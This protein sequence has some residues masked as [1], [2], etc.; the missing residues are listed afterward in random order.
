MPAIQIYDSETVIENFDGGTSG[1]WGTIQDSG[2]ATATITH[3]SALA[4]E[5]LSPFSGD[6]VARWALSGGDT[7]YYIDL[8]A[9]VVDTSETW[10]ILFTLLIEEDFTLTASDILPIFQMITTNTTTMEMGIRNNAGQYELYAG[11][12]GA[13]RTLPITRDNKKWYQIELQMDP[14]SGGATGTM[15]FRVDGNAVGAQIGSLQSADATKMWLGICNEGETLNSTSGHFMISDFILN[16][17]LRVYPRTRFGPSKTIYDDEQVFIGPCRL[18]SVHFTTET[19]NQTLILTDTDDSLLTNPGS[20]EIKQVLKVTSAGEIV[21]AF[22]TPQWFY[23]GIHARFVNNLF[24]AE[25]TQPR[26]AMLSVNG[27]SPVMSHANYVERGM[28]RVAS[29]PR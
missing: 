22:N 12:S 14:V 21:P 8:S 23:R 11:A 18:D 7:S 27:G 29:W 10:H 25:A 2:T 4:R 24:V 17:D 20:G 6:Y 26:V 9:T 19:D 28:K 3:W 16:E 1:I 15:D 13:T 5:G